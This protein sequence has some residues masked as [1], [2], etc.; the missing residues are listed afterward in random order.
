MTP[1]HGYANAGTYVVTL[2][3]TDNKGATGSDTA[4]MTIANRPPVAS[5]GPDQSGAPGAT[6]TFSG[7][8]STDLDGTIT[9]YSW[10]FGDGS[11]GTGVTATHAYATAGVYT[12]T[13]TV[14][15]DDGAIASDSLVATVT[16]PTSGTWS[17]SM[18][19][20]D[21]DGAYAIAVDDAGNVFVGGTFS[22]SMDLSGATVTSAGGA[23]WF[24]AKYSPSG[25]LLW[26]HNIGGTGDDSLESVAVNDAG[27]VA[28]T[29]R[30]AGT[31]SLGGPALVASGSLDIGVAVYRADGSYKWSK[32]FGGV[33]DDT[34]SA[35]AFD[36]AGNLYMTGYF[37][38]IVNFGGLSLRVPYDTDLD[39]FVAKFD[40]NGAH[41]WSKNFVNT[42]N[43]RGYGI[44]TNGTSV[45]VVGSF[46]NGIDFGGGQLFSQ[47]AMTDAFVA[48]LNASTGA[49]QWARQLGAPDGSE[50]AY[51]VT[52]NTNGNVVVCGAAVK[53]VDFGGGS[54]AALGGSDGFVA[55]YSG[56]SGA[57]VWSRR[58]GGTGNDY[59]YSVAAGADG[60]LV[61][62]GAFEGTASFGG[63]SLTSV[64]QSDAYVAKYNAG[65][66]AVWV[67]GLGGSGADTGQE[68]A[69]APTGNPV[70]S[71]Y[72][73]GSGVFD[74]TTLTGAGSYDGFVTKL[75]P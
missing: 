4:T 3:V 48:V 67:R 25:A 28:V 59:A 34:G 38:G 40:P 44:A 70:V 39:V 35:V 11:T 42:G 30:F 60:T 10:S 7:A 20:T 26:A 57:H 37:R 58:L 19:G 71:G 49:Y 69:V 1:S 46:S 65:G 22:G 64:G 14:R 61:V 74:G 54:L 45:A 18:G 52:F 6:L 27:E 51:G 31:A 29:G 21:I 36:S 73:Y 62:A 13:L 9:S 16:V 32:G 53:A 12:V 41:V 24:L 66:G 75:N 56:T 72:F 50:T 43:D 8:G 55:A 68:V 63:G 2:T 5:A 23:D 33:Y 17:R 47:N 15:D